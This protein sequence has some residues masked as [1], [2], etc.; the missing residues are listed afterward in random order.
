MGDAENP[1]NHSLLI[2]FA[3]EPVAG[4]V[5]TRLIPAL[6]AVGA[7]ELHQ[8]LV[9]QT[10]RDLLAVGTARV[11]I[12]VAGDP[13]HPLFLRC[14]DAGVSGLYRQQGQDLGERMADAIRR[15]LQQASRVILVGSDCPQLDPAYLRGALAALAETP[16]VLGPARDGGYVLVGARQPVD[17]LFRNVPW[18]SEQVLAVTR[19]NAR[20]AGWTVTLLEE[21]V[22]IDWPADLVHCAGLLPPRHRPGR[23]R[24]G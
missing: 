12:W 6:G 2:Q 10:C 7:C 17:A 18:G 9:L 4:A 21:R 11:Q 1:A 22:D 20:S 5:K 16:V 19:A 24:S 3:R 14:R 8:A 23:D 13:A 15:G